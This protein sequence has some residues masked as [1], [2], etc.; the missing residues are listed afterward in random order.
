ML[1]KQIH[2]T[3]IR[4]GEI[5]LAFRKW[6][7]PSVKKGSLLKTAVGQIEIVDIAKVKSENITRE[8]AA[9]AGFQRLEDLV[10]ILNAT[11]EGDIYKINVRY[12]SPDPRIELRRQTELSDEEFDHLSL[13]L[14]RLDKYS[15]QGDWTLNIL[16][17]IL[18]NPKL[19][20]ADLAAKTGKEKEWL[21]LNVRKLK[22]LGLTIS[23]N[24]GYTISP[25][26]KVFLDRLIKNA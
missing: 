18:N 20:A 4:S 21:K 6:K 26:G 16:K 15:K 14:K 13:R 24:P 5:S 25:L 23:H 17:V 1:F 2:L 10:D 3:G 9:S 11:G 22:N 19:R 8:D 7:R 12:H